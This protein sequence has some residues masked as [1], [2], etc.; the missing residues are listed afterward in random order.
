KHINKLIALSLI[1]LFSGC[2]I[3]DIEPI[4][5]LTQDNAI[6]DEASA[7]RVLNGVYDLGREFDISFF[8]LH[9]AAYGNEGLINGYL[10]GMDGFNNNEVPVQ[11]PFLANVYNGNYKVINTAN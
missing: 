5:Q 3:D 4:N 1:V 2:A 7:E 8:S 9:L 11:N 6:Y 10:S